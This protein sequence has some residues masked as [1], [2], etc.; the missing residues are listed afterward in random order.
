MLCNP[1]YIRELI[2]AEAAVSQ[3]V[4]GDISLLAFRYRD[5]RGNLALRRL[6]AKASS[7][8]PPHGTGGRP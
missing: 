7:R 4:T 8:L 3:S 2:R 6:A 5:V 1:P